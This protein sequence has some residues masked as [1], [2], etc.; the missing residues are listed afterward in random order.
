MKGRDKILIF[1][2]FLLVCNL[3]AL[4]W[5]PEPLLAYLAIVLLG[6]STVL[7]MYP[8]GR[9]E[10]NLVFPRSHPF[11]TFLRVEN[12]ISMP[13][14]FA[15]VF[16]GIH[17]VNGSSWALLVGLAMLRIAPE[18][19]LDRLS[20]VRRRNLFS[21]IP[22]VSSISEI[23]ES[24]MA[25]VQGF[26]FETRTRRRRMKRTLF[27][28]WILDGSLGKLFVTGMMEVRDLTERV[29]EGARASVVGPTRVADGIRAINPVASLVLPANWEGRDSE[30]MD[31]LRRRLLLHRL[32]YSV[33]GSCVYLITVSILGYVVS[34][35][36]GYVAT[37]VSIVVFA[38]LASG[39]FGALGEK[40]A[41][42]GSSYDVRW[43][44]EPRWS[45]LS[46]L[47]KANRLDRLRHKAGSGGIHWEY[48]RL[49]E[50]AE[51]GKI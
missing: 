13:L 43:Y 47:A 18:M 38:L 22:A 7:Y 24:P 3:L 5:I 27:N 12:A 49:L 19:L 46:Q 48:I 35:L 2:I 40:S 8:E 28:V 6:A 29:I 26:V 14:T 16:A 15:L 45:E 1:T 34:Q 10:T 11:Y 41:R 30:W 42:E 37:N 23:V 25:K 17:A 4:I 31:V 32:T 36:Q 51:P 20:Y 44:F 39:F 9:G 33:M 21:A 50:D